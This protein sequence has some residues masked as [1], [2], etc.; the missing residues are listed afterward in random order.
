VGFGVKICHPDRCFSALMETA[1]DGVCRNLVGGGI[2]SGPWTQVEIL[3]NSGL[4]ECIPGRPGR[5]GRSPASDP[6]FG[7]PTEHCLENF[8]G[9]TR[10]TEPSSGAV[11][12][13]A[14]CVKLLGKQ[15]LSTALVK[16]VRLA[17]CAWSKDLSRVSLCVYHNP[18]IYFFAYDRVK[19]MVGRG[20]RVVILAILVVWQQRCLTP[21]RT[22][23]R[24]GSLF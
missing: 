2:G 4:P 12:I 23:V 17:G 18:L 6:R 7:A 10:E 14:A 20:L 24:A 1:V 13:I 22:T 11:V 19:G 16:I 21:W 15:I 3:L 8:A 9:A 5:T